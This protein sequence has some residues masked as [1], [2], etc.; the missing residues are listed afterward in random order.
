MN[1]TLF[2]SDVHLSQQH[3]EITQ[4]FI[5][6][7]NNKAWDCQ[8]LYILGDLFEYW[9][10][11]DAAV[12]ELSVTIQTALKKLSDSGSQIF[13]LHG[14]RDFLI[15]EAFAQR[16]G[17]TLL[18][19]PTLIEVDGQPVIIAH[20]DAQCTDD[21]PYQEFRK[22][23]RNPEWQSQFLSQSIPDRIAYAQQAREKSA[24]HTQSVEQEITDVNT[25][26]IEA[27]LDSYP[28]ASLLIHGHTHRPATH[29]HAEKTRIVLG[30]WYRVSSYLQA[31]A[32]QFQ[33]IQY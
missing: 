28:T 15:G 8:A 31:Q 17:M 6:F 26:A 27:L 1:K 19:D 16:C 11:D 29:Q 33:L 5:D 4:R 21:R 20:G 30:D 18:T 14:N 32:G 12:D 2:V 3:P 23:V 13:Y 22:M 25:A 9:I 24:A 7:L 10:G